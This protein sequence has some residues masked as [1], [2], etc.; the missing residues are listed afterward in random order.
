MTLLL[1]I[2]TATSTAIWFVCHVLESKQY[3]CLLLF[4]ANAAIA[5]LAAIEYWQL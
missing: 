5:A 4:W 2:I 3:S 1:T